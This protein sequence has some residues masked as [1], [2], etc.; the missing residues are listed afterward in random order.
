MGSRLWRKG[1]AVSDTKRDNV[2]DIKPYQKR[3]KIMGLREFAERFG[4]TIPSWF[5]LSLLEGSDS[6]PLTMRD[7]YAHRA[8][9]HDALNYG[10]RGREF[11]H[12]IIDEEF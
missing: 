6:M 4:F 2:I 3:K 10:L 11:N 1:G 12:I 5:D 8:D 7:P 9:L